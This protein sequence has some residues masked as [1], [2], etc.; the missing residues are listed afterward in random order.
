M[1]IYNFQEKIP[2]ESKDCQ[3]QHKLPTKDRIELQPQPS[4]HLSFVAYNNDTFADALGFKYFAEVV[5]KEDLNKPNQIQAYQ[6]FLC[7]TTNSKNEYTSIKTLDHE[8]Y[9]TEYQFFAFTQ[10]QLAQKGCILVQSKKAKMMIEIFG[11]NKIKN[12]AKRAKYAGLL[13]NIY[14]PIC[15]LSSIDFQEIDD[16]ENELYC[17]TDGCG[18]ISPDL[19]MD[20]VTSHLVAKKDFRTQREL[21]KQSVSLIQVRLPAVK[22]VLLVDP[23]LP[24]STIKIRKSMCKLPLVLEKCLKRDLSTKLVSE[25]PFHVLDYSHPS[26]FVFLNHQSLALFVK[27]GIAV[28]VIKAKMKHYINAVRYMTMSP[29]FALNFLWI[30]G[31]YDFLIKFIHGF[32][33]FYT[34]IRQDQDTD[35][36]AIYQFRSEYWERLEEMQKAELKRWKKKERWV[37]RPEE[38]PGNSSATRTPVGDP[39]AEGADFDLR[40]QLPVRGVMLYGASDPS[41]TPILKPGECFA[42]ITMD[43]CA[44]PV[45]LSGNVAIFRYPCYHPGDIQVMQAVSCKSLEHLIDVVLFPVLGSRPAADKMS[46][47]DLDG[48]KFYIIWETDLIPQTIIPAF[49]YLPSDM[50]KMLTKFADHYKIP[51]TQKPIQKRGKKK[52]ADYI[53]Q[54]VWELI[55]DRSNSHVSRTDKLMRIWHRYHHPNMK[56]Q[57]EIENL[58]VSLFNVGIDHEDGLPSIQKLIEMLEREIYLDSASLSEIGRMDEWLMDE[59]NCCVDNHRRRV[60]QNTMLWAA[61]QADC[62]HSF[63]ALRCVVQSL[64]DTSSAHAS[65]IGSAMIPVQLAEASKFLPIESNITDELELA[66]RGIRMVRTEMSSL[67]TTYTPT[68]WI[69]ESLQNQL[70]IFNDTIINRCSNALQDIETQLKVKQTESGELKPKDLFALADIDDQIGIE[71]CEIAN[72]SKQLVDV[73]SFAIDFD[74]DETLSKEEIVEKI[75]EKQRQIDQLKVLFNSITINEEDLDLHRD[76]QKEIKKLRKRATRFVQLLEDI[77]QRLHELNYSQTH[78]AEMYLQQLEKLLLYEISF[79]EKSEI[80]PVYDYRREILNAV[81]GHSLDLSDDK[82]KTNMVTISAK[83]SRVVILV[84]ETGSGKS[85]CAPLFILNQQMLELETSVN[86]RIC[87]AQPRRTATTE[88]ATFIAKTRNVNLGDEIGYHIG[89]GR[90]NQRAV[91]NKNKTVLECVTYGVLL[92]RSSYDPGFAQFSVVFV[93]EVHEDSMDLYVLL[94]TLKRALSIN[95]GLK[96]VLMSAAVN[97]ERLIRFFGTSSDI[98]REISTFNAELNFNTILNDK[99]NQDNVDGVIRRMNI[100]GKRG[101]PVTVNFYGHCETIPRIY[102]SNIV[103][104]CITLHQESQHKLRKANIDEDPFSI[105]GLAKD[106]KE[107]VGMNMDLQAKIEVEEKRKKKKNKGNFEDVE[108]SKDSQVT[109]PDILVFLPTISDILQACDKLKKMANEKGITNLIALPL[110]SALTDE[111]KNLILRPD[112]KEL[113]SEKRKIIF[114]TNVA[115]TS[116]TIPRYFL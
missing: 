65:G 96:I 93:D 4:H 95:P 86:K 43:G 105:D 74:K 73:F 99:S 112:S 80:L 50:K 21:L 34:K 33:E 25:L 87:V 97:E 13:F 107:V 77:L 41:T 7:G 40:V 76:I 51:F 35:M 110:Y 52:P 63:E 31:K 48:D 44:S 104:L 88:L 45:T 29:L 84:S 113:V 28:D 101:F 59:L 22:G 46:G 10:N 32:S 92:N 94:G 36:A 89:R 116:L 68:T 23:S 100:K 37:K 60:G 115:E 42:R 12:L 108:E 53:A 69:S 79:L 111:E 90:S 15:I 56:N 3:S 24:E 1:K 70:S 57:N 5:F 114:S 16:T 11:L 82:N 18:L 106:R 66:R 26:S 8:K 17:F 71:E 72:L 14:N 49:S 2:K 58:L 27:R 6:S 61:F 55:N 85:T 109:H 102:I 83:V 19:I 103:N 38:N 75:K 67:E 81:F 30:T 91:I 64:S 47:G 20:M 9:V 98:C 54:D 62:F 78:S 39:L